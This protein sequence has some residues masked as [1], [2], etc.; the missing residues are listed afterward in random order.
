MST[1]PALVTLAEVGGQP[2]CPR[3]RDRRMDEECERTCAKEGSP[4]VCDDM[5][6]P[7]RPFL[8]EISQTE[9]D[10]CLAVTYTR[11]LSKPCLRNSAARWCQG[12]GDGEKLVKGTRFLSYDE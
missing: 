9:N 2:R 10:K 1:L 3:S 11:K 8:S 7:G 12:R 6:E 4:A 5:E